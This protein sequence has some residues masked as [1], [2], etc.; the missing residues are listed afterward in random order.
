[1]KIRSLPIQASLLQKIML[2]LCISL[3]LIP[4]LS[5]AA[6]TQRVYQYNENGRLTVMYTATQK[7]TYS[8]DKNGNLVSKQVEQ[9]DYNSVVNPTAPAPTPTPEPTPAPTPTPVPEPVTDPTLI[10]PPVPTP[11]K[12]G[13]KIMYTLDSTTQSSVASAKGGL[14]FWGWYLDPVG[15]QRI[16]VYID[17]VFHGRAYMGASREDVYKVYPDYNNHVSGFY[18]NNINITTDGTP[19]T[20]KNKKGKREVI[21]GEFVHGVTLK[22]VNRANVTTE[23]GSSVVINLN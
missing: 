5:A 14:A 11:A 1:M 12:A 10:P 19:Y 8:Y 21:P 3:V 17:G 15:I 23:I 2:L 16:D 6:A 18:V 20:K 22:V 13:L 7:T 9:G 4:V